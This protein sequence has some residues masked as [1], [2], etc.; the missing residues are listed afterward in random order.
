MSRSLPD[1]GSGPK[2][3]MQKVQHDQIMIIYYYLKGLVDLRTR[4]S[5]QKNTSWL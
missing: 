1:G 5:L 4:V 3:S 2:H